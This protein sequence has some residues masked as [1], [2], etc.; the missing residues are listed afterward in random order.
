M[1]SVFVISSSGSRVALLALVLS[2]PLMLISRWRWIKQDKKRWLVIALLIASV[3]GVSHIHEK[4]RGMSNAMNKI[5]AMNAGFSG[6]V[7]LGMY[8]IALDLI[9]DKPWMGHGIG[10]FVRVWQLA[11]PAFYARHPTARLPEKR[12]GHPHNELIYWLVEGGVVMAFSLALVALVTLLSLWRL[13]VSRRYAYMALLIPIA[14]HT[15]VELPFYISSLHWFLFLFLLFMAL[16]PSATVYSAPYLSKIQSPLQI[17]A[18][19][20]FVIGAA[21]LVHSMA[22][23]LEIK[24]YL[25][26]RLAKTTPFPRGVNNPYFSQRVSEHMMRSLLFISMKAGIKK[27][28]RNYADWGEK[29]LKYNPHIVIYKSTAM[30]F[31]YLQEADKQCAIATEGNAVY[32]MD[33]MLKKMAKQCRLQ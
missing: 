1:V 33:K 19:S 17:S 31:E 3:A 28:A 15:Q 5:T 24:H 25:Q 2:L 22:S 27:N 20:L 14:L 32:P 8:S 29:T 30:A 13:T 4:N 21:F 11:K 16:T 23:S 7:R 10:S 26:H 12:V 18:L 9:K 6:S